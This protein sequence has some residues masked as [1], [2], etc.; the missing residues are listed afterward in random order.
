MFGDININKTLTF[1]I[2]FDL[3]ANLKRI[4]PVTYFKF[5]PL[6]QQFVDIERILN[7]GDYKLMV[8]NR[9]YEYWMTDE[10]KTTAV[11][12]PCRVAFVLGACARIYILIVCRLQSTHDAGCH[13]R[14]GADH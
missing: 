10:F 8:E 2:L 11:Y 3:D 9:H 12:W 4:A 5:A 1:Q 6:R 14:T 7:D 13:Q